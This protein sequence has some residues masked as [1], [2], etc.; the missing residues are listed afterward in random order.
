MRREMKDKQMRK[1]PMPIKFCHRLLSAKLWL[2][3]SIA[4][5]KIENLPN[6]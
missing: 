1:E 4:I 6:S 2:E 5:P 3:P